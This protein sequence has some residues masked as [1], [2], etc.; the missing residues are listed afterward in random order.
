MTKRYEIEVVEETHS[1]QAVAD[2]LVVVFGAV[3][4]AITAGPNGNPCIFVSVDEDS[5][6]HLSF[7]LWLIEG[8]GIMA[9]DEAK[10]VEVLTDAAT[11]EV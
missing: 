11:Y 9:S 10:L 1:A 3:L 6:M 5:A 8:H 4:E 7:K 2:A